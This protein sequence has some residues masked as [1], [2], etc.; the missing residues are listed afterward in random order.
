M[1]IKVSTIILYISIMVMLLRSSATITQIRYL[2]EGLVI[3]QILIFIYYIVKI[4]LSRRKISIFT[5]LMIALYM[6]LYISTYMGSKDFTGYRSYMIQAIGTILI[7]EYGMSKDC[8]KLLRVLKNCLAFVLVVNTITVILYNNGLP[9]INN[10]GYYF[11]GLRIGF[12]PFVLLFLMV[13]L[14][15][16]KINYNKYF[17]K[18]TIIMLIISML[19]LLLQKVATGIFTTA[20]V[21]ALITLYHFGKFN[22]LTLG[23]FLVIYIVCSV[24]ILVFSIQYHIPIVSYVLE[25][26][27][28]KDLS[29]DNR[30]YIWNASI[31]DIKQKPI[32]GYGITG[33][34]DV[35]VKFTFVTKTLTSH[36]QILHILHEGGILAFSLFFISFLLII[37]GIEINKNNYISQINRAI[38][39]GFLLM[40]V[41][42]VQSQK[43]LMFF[44]M[45]IAYYTPKLIEKNNEIQVKSSSL[46]ITK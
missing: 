40:M 17:S 5:M 41:T 36:N 31:N 24:G 29:F 8:I 38:M 11:L 45:A 44:A 14:L 6:I 3:F 4:I 20:I 34:G 22:F 23:K 33:G 39:I 18:Y 9:I 35:V 1:K 37:K 28:K 46:D 27:M 32:L 12:S 19:S 7:V 2:N 30:E 16:D 10:R 15:Y 21:V 42:E 25:D 13:S 26:V 43:S